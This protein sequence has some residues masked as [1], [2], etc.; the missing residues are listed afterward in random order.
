MWMR[1]LDNLE[2]KTAEGFDMEVQA[3][4]ADKARQR[5]SDFHEY[6]DG[7]VDQPLLNADTVLGEED[8]K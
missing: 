7:E 8:D 1:E 6:E 4:A 3:V 5:L 2:N